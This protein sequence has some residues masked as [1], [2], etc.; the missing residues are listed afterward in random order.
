MTEIVISGYYGFGN[1]GDEAMLEATLRGLRRRLDE[2]ETKI[3]VVSGRS[4]QVR[5]AHG[6]EALDRLDLLGIGRA[7]G[8]ADLFLSGG[9]TLLQDRTSFRNLAYHLML[10]EMARRAGSRTM[11]YAQG[12]GPVRTLL[13]RTLA[14]RVL[15][16]LDAIT[17]RDPA[18]AE[19]LRTLGVTDPPAEVTA[20]PAFALEPCR[21]ERT[22]EILRD[23][24]LDT[25]GRPLLALAPRGLRHRELE[26][27]GLAALADWTIRRLK[28]RPLILPMQY[29]NDLVSCDMILAHMREPEGASVVRGRLK[30]AEIMGLLGQCELVVGVRLHALIFA[31][32]VGTPLAGVEYDPKVGYFLS[33]LGFRP[34]ARLENLGSGAEDL[35][36]GL[37]RAWAERQAIREKIA[38]VAPEFRRLAERNFDVASEMAR[39]GR[40]R[41][42]AREPARLPGGGPK[43]GGGPR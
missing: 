27:K 36:I 22:Q 9:G 11:I 6:V 33:R 19:A 21:P 20:D 3:T 30:P 13:G 42:R 5:A 39:R 8:R 4:D 29:P 37:E 32:A 2:G 7:L 24:R 43:L 38:A 10:F 17:V 1:A 25:A 26:A 23:E 34:L 14:S 16:G 40:A 18:S 35:I 15:R 31:A 41:K 12:V 28:A